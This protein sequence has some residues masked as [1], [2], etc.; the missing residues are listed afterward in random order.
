MS[1]ARSCWLS[2]RAWR[3]RRKATEKATNAKNPTPKLAIIGSQSLYPRTS[4]QTSSAALAVATQAMAA[5]SDNRIP[6]IVQRT[7]K[8]IAPKIGVE[9]TAMMAMPIAEAAIAAARN[10][11]FP[12]MPSVRKITTRSTAKAARSPAVHAKRGPTGISSSSATATP[13]TVRYPARCRIM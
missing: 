1:S 12:R 10:P 7:K 8:S 11:A 3:E 13:A 4:R 6:T 5:P 2:A 9:P